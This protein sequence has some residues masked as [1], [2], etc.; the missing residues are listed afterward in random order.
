MRWLEQSGVGQR[1]PFGCLVMLRRTVD[2]V[3]SCWNY[4]FVDEPRWRFHEMTPAPPVHLVEP[5][6]LN[7]SLPSKR[8]G[9]A[10]G[11]NNEALRVLSPLALDE[12]ALGHLTS[13]DEW[14]RYAVPVLYFSACAADTGA[15]LSLAE[16]LA[17]HR[18]A[19]SLP[20]ALPALPPP[21]PPCCIAGAAASW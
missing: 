8:S 15:M 14:S 16:V 3:A 19:G 4:R 1:R 17:P 5:R 21:L 2:R 12:D 20:A 13:A 6:V 11:C 9:H 18:L 7:E 10:E